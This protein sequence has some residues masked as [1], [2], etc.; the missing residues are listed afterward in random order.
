MCLL[1][2]L[3]AGQAKKN[4]T[5]SERIFAKNDKIAEL[6][7]AIGAHAQKYHTGNYAWRVYDILSG[8]DAGGYMIAEKP[9]SWADLDTRGDISPEHTADY[10]NNVAALTTEKSS[11]FYGTFMED[12]S[13]V[14]L[15]DFADKI[16]IQHVFLKPGYTGD[17]EN[18]LKKIKKVWEAAGQTVAVYASSSSGP[19]QYMIV[20]R[21][22]GGFAERDNTF[23]G[24]GF[25]ERYEAANGPGSLNDY[26]LSIR[27]MV[28]SNWG[29]LLILNKN[30]SSK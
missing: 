17:Y 16:A 9:G 19:Q 6:E 1:P 20:T 12:L 21:Y 13:T 8:P 29:E 23:G 27:R 11:T 3:G 7:K 24:K 26:L 10:N 5:S 18:L 25:P 22:K 2:L 15:T 30:M 14:Q 4:V 28:D